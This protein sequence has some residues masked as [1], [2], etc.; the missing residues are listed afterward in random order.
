MIEY[1]DIRTLYYMVKIYIIKNKKC[2]KMQKYINL[3]KS[4]KMQKK[5]ERKD[6]YYKYL[7]DKLIIY[8]KKN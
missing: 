7:N 5:A 4:K 8:D 2:R 6:N 3:I 1:S